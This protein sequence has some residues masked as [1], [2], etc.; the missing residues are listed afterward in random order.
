MKLA[1]KP[2]SVAVLSGML[3]IAGPAMADTIK[4]RIIETTDIHTN[5]MDYD[6]YTQVTS[7]CRIHEIYSCTKT[8]LIISDA[9]AHYRI[10]LGNGYSNDVI[11]EGAVGLSLS[12][13]ESL[14]LV[15]T[16]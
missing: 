3:T 12:G 7:R 16:T 4:L 1:V 11:G 15:A 8:R 10:G 2:L 14:Y 5:V 6:Y 9:I 13:N